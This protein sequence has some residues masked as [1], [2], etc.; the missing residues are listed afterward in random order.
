MAGTG[1]Y[2]VKVTPTKNDDTQSGAPVGQVVTLVAGGLGA[3]SAF[4][5]GYILNV[6]RSETRA[7]VSH[8]DGNATLEGSLVNWLDTDDLDIFDS[9]STIQA[10]HD[11]LFTD[12]STAAYTASQTIRLFVGT[13]TETVTVNDRMQMPLNF[14]LTFEANGSDVVTIDGTAANCVKNFAIG[15]IHFVGIIFASTGTYCLSASAISTARSMEVRNCTFGS[16]RGIDLGVSPQGS[17]IVRDST[18]NCSQIGI[19]AQRGG[20]L[21]V[22]R[23]EFIECTLWTIQCQFGQMTIASN[24][25]R[26][27]ANA[28]LCPRDGVYKGSFIGIYNNT[29]Y[30]STVLD[31][32]AEASEALMDV[33]AL[34]NIHVNSAIC[35]KVSTGTVLSN[36]NGNDIYNATKVA[37]VDGTPYTTL[38]NWQAYTDTQG[39]AP[40]ADTLDTDP[41]MTDPGAGDFSL[42]AASP[43]RHAGHGSGVLSDVAGVAYD[44][45]HPDI[46]A[47][48]T[49]AL[50]VVAPSIT[51]AVDDASG[52][53]VTLTL[54]A[55]NELDVLT[56]RYRQSRTT[57]STTD[58]DWTVFGSTR[59]GDGTLQI[60]GLSTNKYDFIATAARAN[61]IS[62]PSNVISATVTTGATIDV[63]RAFRQLLI[64]DATVQGLVDARV[65]RD[66]APQEGDLPIIVYTVVDD[67]P[68]NHLQAQADE[69]IARVR[70]DAYAVKH[71]GARA[72]ADAVREATNGFRGTVTTSD[73]SLSVTL[74]QMDASSDGYIEPATAQEI[75][76]YMV[77]MDFR[78]GHAESV[79]TFA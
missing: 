30:G 74:L 29:F 63:A 32:G 60:T 54:D 25:F 55:D 73:G 7:I 4:A 49:G 46:G 28:I 41:L 27:C 53:T 2:S 23:C 71:D 78:V 52:T 77:R 14:P 33:V 59:T 69:A 6:T 37:D 11:Q 42:Q 15:A 36:V 8:N 75:G 44:V 65:Y 38:A 17:L 70:C 34:N 24:T 56:V 26:D 21:K 12:Q 57:A 9:W 67:V 68:F 35:Y 13:Y 1:L 43:A 40:D 66:V 72:L 64:D 58:S 61:E 10:A 18:Y 50:T 19:A 39:N 31:I 51:T 62:L 22:E 48:S 76:I 79:P 5:G 3:A 20:A 16:F 47:K 45:H